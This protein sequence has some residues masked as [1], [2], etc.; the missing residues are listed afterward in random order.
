M[1]EI[2]N[3]AQAATLDNWTAQHSSLDGFSAARRNASAVQERR[4]REAARLYADVLRGREHPMMLQE[5]MNPRTDLFIGH[6][7]EKYPG[8]YGDPG[9][10]ML[11]LRE[12]MAVTDYQALYVDVLDRLYYGWYNSYPIPNKSLV[13]IK[14]L[15]DF[16]A[17]KRYMM[18]GV[19]SPLTSSDPGAQIPN[20]SLLGPTPQN[21]VSPPTPSTSTAA[22]TYSPLLYQ[23]MTSVNWSAIVDDDLGIFQD[24]AQRLAI[25]GNQGINKF[26]TSLYVDAAGPHASLY[27]S[28]YGNLINITNGAS[29]NNPPLS[30]QGIMDGMKI[31]AGMRD[32]SGNPIMITG[33]PRCWY[34]PALTATAQNLKRA[35]TISLSVEGGNQAGTTGFPSQWL[36]VANWINDMDLVMDP[37]IPIVCTAAGVQHTVWGIT[38]D[39]DSQNRP[40]IEVGFLQG[41]ETPQTFSRVP[42]TQR[43]GG[44]VDPMLG[45]FF[46]MNQ[47]LKILTVMGGTQIDGR[48]TVAS[49]GQSV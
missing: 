12:T 45:D 11:G 8:L 21:G 5:A 26:I 20:R 7:M 48:S 37:Y 39:P 28:G 49:T 43:V 1:P 32:S 34:G 40:A 35:L 15:R 23:A 42:T 18:D 3:F 30:A 24:L 25:S 31:L 13:K 9:G 10:R 41:Y 6:L 27:T 47:D 38:I 2:T 16:R 33:R 46:T 17:V 14:T 22:V 19:V 29:I 4:I 44:G 36:Q